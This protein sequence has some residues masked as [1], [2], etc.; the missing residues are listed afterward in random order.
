METKEKTRFDTRLTKEQ[1]EYF[2]HA[3]RLGGFKTLSDF[4]LTSAKNHADQIM[5]LHQQILA[6]EKDREVFFYALLH[7][8]KPNALLKKAA[9]RY[10]KA[11]GQ[12]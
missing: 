2:E 9:D 8:K 7:P 1:K 10:K 4:I 5:E 12:Q 6:S 3:S 11:T